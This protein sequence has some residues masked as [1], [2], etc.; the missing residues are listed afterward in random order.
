MSLAIEKI[1]AHRLILGDAYEALPEI[2]VSLIA[3]ETACVTD[4]PYAFAASGGG[5]MRAARPYLDLIERSE[6]AEGF[7]DAILRPEWFSSVVCFCHNDQ[8]F[9]GLP[10]ALKRRFGQAALLG[11]R[12]T[13]PPPFR[14]KHYLPDLELYLHAW[15]PG[16]HPIG[17]HADMGRIFEAPCGKSPWPHP[18]V[19]PLALMA[20]I[21]RNVAAP[22]IVDPFMGTGTTGVAAI[23][24]GRRFVGI[25]KRE[26]W[27]AIAAKRIEEA[28][29]GAREEE[30]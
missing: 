2:E 19:K 26:E 30:R 6:L 24:A 20:K 29:L 22:L 1:G 11:W 5:R 23:A 4:P 18:T 28:S 27:F 12:K 21:I 13:N 10:A 3:A 8:L 25:E 14:N 16:A 9:G 15:T 7:D 17:A